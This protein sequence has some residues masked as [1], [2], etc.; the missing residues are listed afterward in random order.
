MKKTFKNIKSKFEYSKQGGAVLLGCKKLL[1]KAHGNSKA[2]SF[3]VA[4][5]QMYNMHKGKL[6]E[7]ISKNLEKAGMSSDE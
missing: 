5:N 2:D 1:V 4:I 7:K 3:E 6:I